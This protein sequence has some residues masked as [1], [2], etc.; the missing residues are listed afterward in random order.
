MSMKIELSN[1][2]YRTILNWYELSFAKADNSTE[3][4]DDTCDKLL[5]MIDTFLE[6]EGRG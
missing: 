2:D 3:Q 1:I 5:V 6:K 4:D